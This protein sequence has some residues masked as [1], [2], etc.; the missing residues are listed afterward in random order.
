M[1]YKYIVCCI[2]TNNNFLPFFAY[3]FSE[4]VKFAETI[5][6]GDYAKRI[7]IHN[8]MTGATFEYIF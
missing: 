8:I 7:E 3:T 6:N 2:L 5:S 1:R 4:A